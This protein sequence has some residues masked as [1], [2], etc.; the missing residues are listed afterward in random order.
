MKQRTNN[1]SFCLQEVPRVVKLIET[2]CEV[3]VTWELGVG[4]ALL[5]NGYRVLY[6]VMKSSEELLYIDVNILNTTELNT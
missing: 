6:S 5:F 1:V 3:G 2:E 4:R